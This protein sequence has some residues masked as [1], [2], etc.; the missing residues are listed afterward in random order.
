[1]GFFSR[2]IAFGVWL[3]VYQLMSIFIGTAQPVCGA[4]REFACIAG[5]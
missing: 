3:L 5:H 2:V 1:M 4:E